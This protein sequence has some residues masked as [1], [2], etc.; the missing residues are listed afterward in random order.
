MGLGIFEVGD[1]GGSRLKYTLVRSVD[2][3]EG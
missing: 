3:V 1:G 2:L